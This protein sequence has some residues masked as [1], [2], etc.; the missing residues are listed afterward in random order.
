MLELDNMLGKVESH[1]IH[2]PTTRRLYVHGANTELQMKL[3]LLEIEEEKLKLKLQMGTPADLPGLIHGLGGT[4]PSRLQLLSMD[5]VK[6]VGIQS[7]LGRPGPTITSAELAASRGVFSSAQAIPAYVGDPI[8]M[9]SIWISVKKTAEK[10]VLK[11]YPTN[12]DWSGWW[13]EAVDSGRASSGRGDDG[14]TLMMEVEPKSY[15]EL[16]CCHLESRKDMK[17][18]QDFDMKLLTSVTDMC[19]G[20]MARKLSEQKAIA[21]RKKVP[22]RGR[23]AM[24]LIRSEFVK[25]TRRAATMRQRQFKQRMMANHSLRL[26]RI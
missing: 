23:P 1:S 16:V 25:E 4:T 17:A 11:K 22:Y 21:G 14:W 3:R 19:S 20:P 6:P 18:W 5:S 24:H 13:R 9:D 26:K 8:S 7:T 2:T 15:E 12:T 10:V